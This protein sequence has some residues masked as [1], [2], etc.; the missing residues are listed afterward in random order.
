MQHVNNYVM[1]I[2]IS[3]KVDAIDY[4]CGRLLVDEILLVVY[5]GL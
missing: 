1:T 2:I 3:I 4:F 5:R